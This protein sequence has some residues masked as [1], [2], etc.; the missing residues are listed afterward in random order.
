MSAALLL[1]LAPAFAPQLGAGL[2]SVVHSASP[3]MGC[4]ALRPLA[5]RTRRHTR[6]PSGR[7]H[8]RPPTPPLADSAFALRS[9]F[10][11]LNKGSFYDDDA[12]SK[13]LGTFQARAKKQQVRRRA[14]APQP[15]PAARSP[16]RTTPM[17]VRVRV[18]AR[19]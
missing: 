17:R 18:R 4:A 1:L 6:A 14:A 5:L 7:A 8:A 13:E 11:G 12:P 19:R 16:A 3:R 2:R 9:L 15:T 10:D